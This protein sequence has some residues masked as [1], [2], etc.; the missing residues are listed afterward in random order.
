MVIYP[1]N[2]Q[3]VFEKVY[4]LY[5]DLKMVARLR[6]SDVALWITIVCDCMYTI[7][8]DGIDTAGGKILGFIVDKET[9]HFLRIAYQT[10]PT[11]RISISHQRNQA[12][13]AFNSLVALNPVI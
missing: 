6:K 2:Y 4:G 12:E 13:R 3:L 8:C 5:R 11:V 10:I 9:K 7:R 1:I